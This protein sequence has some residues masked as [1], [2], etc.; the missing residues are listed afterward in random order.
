MCCKGYR[1]RFGEKKRDTAWQ[2]SGG[3]WEKTDQVPKSLN[4]KSGQAHPWA[5]VRNLGIPHRE[6]FSVL[7]FFLSSFFAGIIFSAGL[8]GGLSFS[9]AA[10]LTSW[11]GQFLFGGSV[12]SIV[13][14]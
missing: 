3:S 14:F 12:L 8:V 10:L 9:T 1:V 11:A 4:R 7:F 5:S 13:A 2:A 6:G